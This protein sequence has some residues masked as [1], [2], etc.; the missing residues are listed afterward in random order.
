MFGIAWRYGVTL[1]ELKAANPDVNPNLLS[2]GTV[3]I[4]PASLLPEPSSQAPT[5]TP[6]PLETGR[7]T[8]TRSAE[9]GAW[10]FWPVRNPQDFALENISAIFRLADRDAKNIQPRQAFLPLDVLPPG[11]SLPL[12]A[13]YPPPLPDPFQA[14]AELL[15]V[16]PNPPDDGRYLPTR[17][18][19]QQVSIA[20]DG[21]SAAIRAELR[22]QDAGDS[23]Q[24]AWVAV[25]AYD[26]EG[27]VAGM[28][29]WENTGAGPLAGGQSLTVELEVF[30]LGAPIARVELLAE[31]RP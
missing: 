6:I 23:A 12:M 7:L 4:I 10:C 25:V 19:N 27:N 13:Y 29:R 5:P 3:L 20:A 26:A 21:R 14:S 11:A 17:L 28:R 18:L 2:V 16:L 8:C 15:T 22:L 1:E 30:S 24:R 31:A 9:G